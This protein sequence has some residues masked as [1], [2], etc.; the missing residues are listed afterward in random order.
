MRFLQSPLFV[1]VPLLAIA[2]NMTHD[3]PLVYFGV[4]MT[5]VN[6]SVALCLDWCVTFPEGRVGRVLN[7]APLVYVGWLSYS[8]YLWQQPF[9]NRASQAGVA[10][11]PL[12]IALTALLAV[13]SY[14]AVERPALR[15]RR[16][17]ERRSSAPSALLAPRQAID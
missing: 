8:L 16:V 15:L 9:L 17:L 11:F 3:H 5:L 13:V 6:I 10:A 14:Y 12:N 2:G 4:G 7:A 1:A